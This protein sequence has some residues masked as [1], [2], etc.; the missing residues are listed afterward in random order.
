MSGPIPTRVVRAFAS[1]GLTVLLAG[2]GSSTP[3]AASATAG[4]PG[5]G[6]PGV[7]KVRAFDF[8]FD[9]SSLTVPAGTVTFAVTNTGSL[10]HEFEVFRGDQVVDEVEGLVPGLS[11]QL[12]VTLEPG[13]Y[14][15]VCKIAG[16][17]A[18][19]MKGALTVTS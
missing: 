7:V 16:H 10:E 11:R 1:V 19:G 17:E 14:T 8:G 4:A 6:A 15:Y 5:S 13:A 3:G 18:A 2:C 12:S 9:P